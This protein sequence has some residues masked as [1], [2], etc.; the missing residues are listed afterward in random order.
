[1]E[2]LSLNM[3]NLDMPAPTIAT[4]LPSLLRFCI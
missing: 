3:P 4:P 1:L 2:S